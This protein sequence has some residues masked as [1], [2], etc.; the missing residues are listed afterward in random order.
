MLILFDIDMTLLETKHIG[1]DCLHDAGRSLFTPDFTIDGIVFGGCL[2]PVIITQMLMLNKIDP[3]K[4]HIGA[5]RMHYHANLSAIAQTRSVSRALPGAHNLVNAVRDHTSKPTLGLLT[6]NFAET[7]TI[8]ITAA[9]FNPD[10]FTINAWGDASPHPQP[11][12]SHLPPVA[13]QN[14]KI[15]KG[16]E[17]DP[18][19]VIIIGDT[20][21][22][23]SC[24]K[25]SGCRVLA[26]A[27]GHDSREA[28][29]SQGADLVV[30]DLT[31]TGEI[32]EWIMNDT[33]QRSIR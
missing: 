3:T 23:V 7:G 27:T 15:A 29:E 25:D 10:D 12:R 5:M 1:I 30:D 9:G 18:Q 17:I 28:L 13:I 26:V 31:Q 19:S 20:I 33:L 2:D 6:G 21:H 14:Y 16:V 8:K 32:I 22:D 24:A 4:E 11:I